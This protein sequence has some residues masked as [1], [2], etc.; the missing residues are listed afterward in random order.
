MGKIVEVIRYEL[1]IYDE[2]E[3][4]SF[5]HCIA[6]REVRPQY[7]E[8]EKHMSSMSAGGKPKGFNASD[9]PTAIP[10][11]FG[12]GSYRAIGH[13]LWQIISRSGDPTYGGVPQV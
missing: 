1:D 10:S 8:T 11:I 9:H 7:I 4:P 6:R 5:T 13:A 3:L 2:L 12:R